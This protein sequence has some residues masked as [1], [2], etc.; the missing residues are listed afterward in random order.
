MKIAVPLSG[1]LLCEHFGHCETFAFF[2]VAPENRTVSGR[3]SSQAPEHAPGVLPAWLRQQGVT[4]VLAGGIG[5]R[6]QTLLSQSGIEVVTGAPKQP[7]EA[8]VDAYLHGTLVSI[9]AKCHH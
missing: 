1:G 2:D 8:L 4:V 3:S 7:A 5:S 6:A 9:P